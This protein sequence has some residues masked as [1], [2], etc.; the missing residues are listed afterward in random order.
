MVGP[1]GD[2][3]NSERG[4]RRTAREEEIDGAKRVLSEAIGGLLA[5]TGTPAFLKEFTAG[6]SSRGEDDDS[7]DDDDD[8]D[9]VFTPFAPSNGGA[10]N[11]K[12]HEQEFLGFDPSSILP[13][14]LSTPP[15]WPSLIMDRRSALTQTFFWSSS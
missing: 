11:A 13:D 9:P 5:S 4:E 10:N 7:D 15:V 3:N 8:L 6:K 2:K 12:A 1:F 14:L